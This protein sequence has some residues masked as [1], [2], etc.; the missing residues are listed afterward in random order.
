M[1]ETS[2][3]YKTA[4]KSNTR[5]F[6]WYGSIVTTSGTEYDFTN[7]DIVKESGQITRS[8]CG[9]DDLEIG[10]VYASTLE[11]TLLTSISAYT[12][13]NAVVKIYFGLK[14]E[15]GTFEEIPCGI[16]LISDAVRDQKTIK[17]TAY[18]Y[19]VK[20]EKKFNS[21]SVQNSAF[22]WVKE[23]CTACSVT[24]PDSTIFRALTN[25]TRVL[26]LYEDNDIDTW[27]DVIS[28][29]AQLTGTCARITETGSLYFSAYGVTS[30]ETIALN[31]RYSS[32]ISDFVTNYV[33]IYSTNKRTGK[34]ELYGVD[35]GTG[36][37]FDLGA[38]PFLQ[39]EQY[40]SRKAAMNSLLSTV[41][42]N[43]KFVPFTASLPIDPSLANGNT[44]SFSGGQ[45][46]DGKVYSVTNQVMK[47]NGIMNLTGSGKDPRLAT[48]KTSTEK[49]TSGNSKV[50][51]SGSWII[52]SNRPTDAFTATNTE[53]TISTIDYSI[54]NTSAAY[55]YELTLQHT[56]SSAGQIIVNL[57]LDGTLTDTYT[58]DET[59]G[60]HVLT[61]QHKFDGGTEANHEIL[62]KVLSSSADVTITI[63][64]NDSDSSI[65]GIY[66]DV[67]DPSSDGTTETVP[68]DN[69]YDDY[70]DGKY[71]II[72]DPY[73][74]TAQTGNLMAYSSGKK[75]WGGDIYH[76]MSSYSKVHIT[77]AILPSVFSALSAKIDVSVEQNGSIM[78]GTY[79]VAGN[80]K[81]ELYIYNIYGGKIITPASMENYF[82]DFSSCTEIDF[83]G[84]DMSL[85]KTCTQMFENCRS[86]IKCSYPSTFQPVDL[87]DAF[88]GA[89]VKNA[90]VANID[91][92]KATTLTEI[93]KYAKG[94]DSTLD[95]SGCNFGKVTKMESGFYCNETTPSLLNLKLPNMP[96][97][98]YA[99]YMFIGQSNLSTIYSPTSWTSPSG[100]NT[101]YG[102][103]SLVGGNGY[104]YNE[105]YPYAYYGRINTATVN[106][107]FTASS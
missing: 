72:P 39:Y 69:D 32:D 67:K 103:T 97:L 56:M 60:S 40:A 7:K 85:T 101:F 102:C 25:G 19:M 8:T 100:S 3:A 57:Y 34:D 91:Y 17:I 22:F 24:A 12:L 37:T 6:K 87:S 59:A 10:S 95:L 61:I 21:T 46:V 33:G 86:L 52:F 4:I 71:I 47:F 26:N 27:R 94:Y 65:H 84:C 45:A 49:S 41:N 20:F 92:S 14:L 51:S 35:D 2:A 77:N 62:A 106:G 54:T 48:A 70:W 98:K 89:L 73:D 78:A 81:Y 63:S 79:S 68:Y 105:N 29:I 1:R 9:N 31:E 53:I 28:Y 18:D 15:D 42:T 64:A 11:M 83:G 104:A 74:P 75:I 82:M 43:M 90:T 23:A 96:Y 66:I 16:F 80:P 55:L 30:D 99:E 44:I 38:N 76:S 93:F 88:N 5:T 107:Y 50:S 13:Y 58:E 36:F